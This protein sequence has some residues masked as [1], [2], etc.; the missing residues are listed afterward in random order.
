THVLERVDWKK[1]LFIFSNVSM[2][3]L[4]YTG[5]EVNKGSKGVILGLGEPIR[6]LPQEWS[7]G[8]LSG[9]IKD[10][11]VFSPGCLVVEAPSYSDEKEAAAIIAKMPI[12]KDWPMLVVVDNAAKA[13]RSVPSF[14]WTTF[15]RFEPAADIFSAK[16]ELHGNK[17]SYEGP[18][19]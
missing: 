12:F 4:D 2:D 6:L 17:I 15:T 8:A 5:P 18:V 7:G 10:I 3:T 1:D 19:V 16:T 11:K 14:L 13:T 9:L